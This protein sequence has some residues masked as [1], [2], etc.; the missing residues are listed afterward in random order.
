MSEPR[1]TY[2][3]IIYPHRCSARNYKTGYS[4][5]TKSLP[6][7]TKGPSPMPCCPKNA[8][9]IPHNVI[10]YPPPPTK[11]QKRPI[12]LAQKA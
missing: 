11:S 10:M 1:H 9:K 12:K 3:V 4:K 2:K 7:L 8:P 5:S 6:P